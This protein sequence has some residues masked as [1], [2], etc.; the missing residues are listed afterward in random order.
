MSKGRPKPRAQMYT[1]TQRMFYKSCKCDPKGFA[2][3]AADEEADRRLTG[4][5]NVRKSNICPGCK[6]ARSVNGTCGCW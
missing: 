5:F 1:P 2:G 6:Q 4:G 3:A